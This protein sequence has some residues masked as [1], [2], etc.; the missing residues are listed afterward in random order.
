[1]AITTRLVKG[2]ALTHAELDANFTTL[3]AADVVLTDAVALNTARTQVVE[4]ASTASTVAGGQWV[5]DGA[6]GGEFIRIQGWQQI[7]DTDT[8]VTTPSQTIATGVRTLWTNDGGTTNLKKLPSDMGVSDTLWDTATNKITPIAAFDTY[9]V[10]I[11]FKVQ[12]YA[13]TTP[14][15]EI[16]LDIGG[17]LG[18]IV[19][20]TVPLLKGGAEQ[21]VLIAFPVFAGTTFLANGGGIY[22]TFTGTGSCKIFGSTIVIIRE[23]KNYV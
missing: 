16:E 11:G 20:Y 18:T 22:V 15:I 5:S 8:T 23:S 1:M 6:G 4:A 3:V 14:D 10:R 17:G 13:G 2:S 12:D 19:D 9:N 21:E 7:A